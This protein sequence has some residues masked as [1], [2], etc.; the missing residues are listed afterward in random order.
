MA[1]SIGHRLLGNI[2]QMT[3][4]EF[5]LI[6]EELGVTQARIA[7]IFKVTPR[8]IRHWESGDREIPGPAEVLIE[9]LQVVID[10][11]RHFGL[12]GKGQGHED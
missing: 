4:E 7:E 6:R 11:Q 5:R 1:H 2:I 10:L 8:S 12:L 9:A 3:G